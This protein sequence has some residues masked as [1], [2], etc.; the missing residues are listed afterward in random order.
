MGLPRGGLAA[1]AGCLL[2]AGQ[3]FY[4][5]PALAQL[6]AQGANPNAQG[7]A[8][9]TATNDETAADTTV[10]PAEE[11][12]FFMGAATSVSEIYDSNALGVAH[13]KSDT[14]TQGELDFNL[15]DQSARFQGDLSYS[16]TGNYH[17][18]FH[19]LNG[20][21]NYL[22]AISH[23]ELWQDHLFL[24]ARA[25]A[26]PTF[27]SRLGS[28]DAGNGVSASANT[29]NAYGYIVTPDFALRFDDFAQSDLTVFQSG[30]FFS[31]ISNALIGT[32]LPF[33]GPSSAQTSTVREKLKG[34]DYFGRLEWVLDAFA[35]NSSQRTFK[36]KQRSAEADLEYHLERYFGIIADMGYRHF[37]S[38]PALTR[39]VSG[40]IAMGG[41]SFDPSKDFSL[42]VKAGK[43]YQFTSY[44]GNL[45]Y[46]ITPITAFIATLDDVITTPQDRLLIGLT[47]LDSA[48]GTFFI[49][50]TALPDQSQLP[51]LPAGSGQVINIAPLD[52]LALDNVISRYR[53]ATAGLIH[54]MPRI[55]YSLTAYG[56]LRDYLLPLP[57]L[58][59]RQTIYGADLSGTYDFSRE[60]SATASADYSVAHEFG[61]IDKLMTFSTRL[62][63]TFTS[64]WSAYF[65]TSYLHRNSAIVIAGAGG[66]LADL[67]FSLGLRYAF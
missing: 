6:P 1:L 64:D 54:K 25:F 28:L 63:Y 56:T 34:G 59:E 61:G 32:T 57:G 39:G 62:N 53:T 48:Q 10:A 46:Q 36:Q 50:T 66:N 45:T 58:D 19:G 29:R 30:E 55:T 5:A 65:R 49:P 22:N 40:P 21:Q 37:T 44:T 23:A 2:A 20:F 60:L 27:L 3:A 9:D 17:S 15:H 7:D 18:D 16:L 38:K 13:G 31:D 35:S 11:R 33:S 24:N 51:G 41:F 12:P 26:Y 52:G 14:T 67:Q 43:Q 47:G 4:A 42:V 8:S